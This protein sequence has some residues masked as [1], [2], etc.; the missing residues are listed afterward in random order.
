MKK[1]SLIIIIITFLVF[2]INITTANAIITEEVIDVSPLKEDDVTTGSLQ[3]FCYA[4]ADKTKIVRIVIN[5]ANSNGTANVEIIDVMQGTPQIINTITGLNLGHGNDCTYNSKTDEILFE[6]NSGLKKYRL[7]GNDL[8]Y[9][10]DVT[11]PRQFTGSISAIAYDKDHD[12]YI[13]YRNGK[14]LIT[15]SNFVP[16]SNEITMIGTG[17]TYE[18]NGASSISFSINN[19]PHLYTSQGIGY[20]NNYIYAVFFENGNSIQP[21]RKTT[22]STLSAFEKERFGGNAVYIFD[23]NG[24][25]VRQ[26]FIPKR[27][28]MPDGINYLDHVPEMESIDFS[29]NGK[30]LLGFTFFKGMYDSIYEANAPTTTPTKYLS[31]WTSNYIL[32]DTFN[33]KS[34][35]ISHLPKTNYTQNQDNLDLTGGKINITYYD[36]TSSEI[37]LSNTNVTGFSNENIGTKTLTVSYGGKTTTFDV[38][39]NPKPKEISKI[40]VKTLPQHLEYIQNYEELDIDDGVIKITFDDNSTDEVSM[41]NSGVT[42]SGFNNKSLGTKTLT[43]SYGGKTTTFDVT[44]VKAKVQKIEIKKLPKTI[45]YIQNYDLLNLSE[46]QIKVTYNDQSTQIINLD[47]NNVDVSGFSNETLGTK[48]LTVLYGDK[49]CTFNV[50]IVAKSVVKIEIIKN[51][52]KY[53]YFRNI[54]SLDL[55]GGIM[56]VTYND[57]STQEI[58]L[59]NENIKSTAGFDNSEIGVKTITLNY[60]NITTTFEIEV[61]DVNLDNQIANVP[62]T[63]IKTSLIIIISSLL[64]IF[65]GSIL[66]IK[67]INDIKNVNNI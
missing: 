2:L 28:L 34:I 6:A 66:V 11:F 61:I 29:N 51:P 26:F 19:D 37:D 18:A 1:N 40:E 5:T 56:K 47:D 3:G 23:L 54:E 43:V 64:L 20:W 67:K 63:S 27:N 14:I 60:A 55:T 58:N 52:L 38:T 12:H 48:T 36:N 13:I 30:I 59:T 33:I 39:I 24:N 15:D 10:E 17:N 50:N 25:F 45:D 7:S 44:I 57:Q 9:I 8:V 22:Y 31:F 35:N 41:A 16:V 49:T 62:N 46:G 21:T 4:N 32:H 65:V 42:V 53:Y